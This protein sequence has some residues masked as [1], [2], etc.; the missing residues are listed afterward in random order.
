MSRTIGSR[1]AIALICGLG[2]VAASLAAEPPAK[3]GEKRD[4]M[5]YVRS[6]PPGAKVLLDNKEIGKTNGLFRVEAGVATIILELEGHGQV[7][8]QVSI[9]ADGI[10][11][12]EI[13]LKPQ[14]DDSN[15]KKTAASGP[16]TESMRKLA[17]RIADGDPKA[18]D[19]LRA[20][21]DERR[22]RQPAAEPL[23]R[24]DEVARLVTG[25]ATATAEAG[26]EWVRALVTKL[27]FP[28][29]GQYGLTREHTAELVGKAAQASSM[30]ANPITLTP[31]ELASI[32]ERAL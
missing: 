24:Y 29:L 22:Q 23:R 5:I 28:G 32:L 18:F 14:N 13:E 1:L 15:D 7:K 8:K 3:T 17:A 31:D 9:R 16:T 12:I 6:G 4:T 11:R 10:T 20:T 21:A 19:E 26:I 25:S 30:K 2:S 27:G